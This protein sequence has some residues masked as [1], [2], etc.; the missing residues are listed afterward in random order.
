MLEQKAETIGYIMAGVCK[1]VRHHAHGRMEKLGLY[2]GQNFILHRLWH[3]EGQTQ[4]ALA[5]SLNVSPATVTNSLQ[6]ME[7]DGIIE[8]RPDLED[9]RVSRVYLTD[10][11]RALREHAEA[12]WATIE[13]TACK[14]FTDDER[15]QLIT[16]LTRMR[17]NLHKA[18]YEDTDG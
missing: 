14:G 8:R 17:A 12:A 7:R 5:T 15:A 3:E 16:L 4:T 13:S 10:R 18:L 2:R 6:R 11:G 1:L 9:Q